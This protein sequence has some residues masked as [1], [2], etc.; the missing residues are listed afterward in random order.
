MSLASAV[1]L[2]SRL[3]VSLDWLLLG[4]GAMAL[5][6]DTAS[7]PPM[8]VDPEARRLVAA[9]A[10]IRSAVVRGAILKLAESLTHD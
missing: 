5:D 2:C 8:P 10:A 6:R 4:R 7:G 3:E 1:E 9:F